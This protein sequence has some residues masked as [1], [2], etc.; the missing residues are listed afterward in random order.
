[1]KRSRKI[2]AACT[3]L[4]VLWPIVQILLV[5]VAHTNPWRLMGFAMYATEHDIEVT[6]SKRGE[7]G[8][9]VIVEPRELPPPARD[10]YDEFVACRA[11]LGRLCSPESF[12]RAWRRADP[13]LEPVHID[14]DVDVLR[15]SHARMTTVAHDRISL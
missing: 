14:V 11:V 15:L 1:M 3:W 9:S 7:T 2:V 12:V 4:V 6:L 8:P 10:A 13:S 5:E